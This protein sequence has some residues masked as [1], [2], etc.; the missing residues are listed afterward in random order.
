MPR[1]GSSPAAG[2]G[3]FF[4]EGSRYNASETFSRAS[5]TFPDRRNSDHPGVSMNPVTPQLAAVVR[6][7]QIVRT[8]V[9]PDRIAII[10]PE[11]RYNS[12]HSTRGAEVFRVIVSTNSPDVVNTLCVH[13]DKISLQNLGDEEILSR[14]RKAE[15]ER[16]KSRKKKKKRKGREP[17][18]KSSDANLEAGGDGDDGGDG[19]EDGAE[20]EDG[21]SRIE[22]FVPWDALV[23]DKD[24]GKYAMVNVASG[25]ITPNSDA[26]TQIMR[27][28]ALLGIEGVEV[29][30]YAIPSK[31]NVA[32]DKLAR[33]GLGEG[34][35]TQQ[36]SEG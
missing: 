5:L 8:R 9:V 14:A 10:T 21:G 19:T 6:A 7:L 24:K 32:A 11:T 26:I 25:S 30:F 16:D 15:K 27:E 29:D 28:I 22:G 2:V 13:L 23:V 36:G 35:G 4:G 31:A 12:N 1:P 33:A 20:R 18:N 34:S 17:G 3:V